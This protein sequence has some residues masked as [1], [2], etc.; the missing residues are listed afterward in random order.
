[1]A[2]PWQT[3]PVSWI[4]AALLDS[5]ALPRDAQSLFLTELTMAPRGGKAD[6]ETDAR[7]RFPRLK[8]SRWRTRAT[9]F[10]SFMP[11]NSQMKSSSPMHS[12]EVEAGHQDAGTRDRPSEGSVEKTEGGTQMKAEKPELVRG[13]GK[14]FGD[15]GRELQTS[16][17]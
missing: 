11:S 7:P 13:S 10:A 2:E 8:R 3:R 17:N 1:M 5:E 16:S 4:N 6:C 15:F 12:E 14:V 9:R